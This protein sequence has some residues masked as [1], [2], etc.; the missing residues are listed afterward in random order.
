VI[1]PDVLLVSMPFGP[2]MAPSIGLSLLQSELARNGIAARS[3]YFSIRFAELV[4]W[5]FY[6]GIANGFEP[7]MQELAGEWIFNRALFDVSPD[8]DARYV[9]EI[10]GRCRREVIDRILRARSRVERF[11]DACLD[12]VL[13]ARPRVVGFTST[14][15]QHVASLALAKRIKQRRPDIA[16][17]FG[18]GNCEGA[19]GAE[20]VRQFPF[21]DAAVS[22][23][24][25]LVVV[26]L[27]R[28]LLN[29]GSIEGMPGV[30]TRAEVA[31]GAKQ[32]TS[33]PSVQDMD[34]LAIPNYSDFF[35]QFRASRFAASWQPSLFFETSRGCWWGERQHC[36]FCGLNGTTMRFRSKSQRRALDELVQLAKKYP[37]SDVQVVDNILDMK[38]F[39]EFV[40]ELAR[41]RL[42][43][44]LFYETKSNLRKSQVRQLRRAGITKIQPGIESLSDSVLKLMRKGVTALQNIQLLKWCRELGVEPCWNV[45]WGFPGEAAEEYARMAEIVPLLAHLPPPSAA[46]GLRLDR[47]SP[48]FE[49]AAAFGFT[50]VRPLPCY[51][52]I[53]PLDDA[54][55][56]NLAYS[57]SYRYA[58]PRDPQQYV[59]P[60]LRHVATWQKAARGSALF[61]VDKDNVL[62]VCD[63]R[64][65]ARRTI[66]A[67]RGVD[68]AI[69]L[70]ADAITDIRSLT[71]SFGDAVESRVMRLVKV[72][73]ML[74]DGQRVLALAI[75]V[76]EYQPDR[77]A[78]ARFQRAV[79]K[80]KLHG[81]KEEGSEEVIEENIEE[82]KHEDYE[83]GRKKEDGE[84][85]A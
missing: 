54:A 60:L 64:P 37:R 20:T 13:A 41:L 62:V 52:H 39:D 34:A 4:G 30:R 3:R 74:R 49:Q 29:G 59:R 5:S 40:P 12:E 67:L 24:G 85:A 25:D 65:R 14:F 19:M 2:V 50:D 80:E 26:D 16:I 11:V 77:R 66:I 47:F 70:A 35:K 56:H 6:S 1:L 53:Y 9:D 48:N 57:F 44:E 61:F 51:E 58:Q 45:L 75:P 71:E 8:D 63:L 36:T 68:R 43:L 83:E 55:R 22:G 78:M 28:R 46:S 33:T 17:V 69:Y 72:G 38:Y 23:E 32:W 31:G 84:E 81:R 27:V 15:Q 73:L 21:V 18:G 10:L 42:K 79:R 76:G 7:S 82:T